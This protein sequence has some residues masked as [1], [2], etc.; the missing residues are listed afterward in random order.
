MLCHC[1]SSRELSQVPNLVFSISLFPPANTTTCINYV[2]AQ[3]Q[4]LLSA[5]L[6][7]HLSRLHQIQFQDQSQHE[8]NAASFGPA[9]WP[10]VRN[11]PDFIKNKP[12]FQWIHGF[13]NEM[14]TK[15]A[16]TLLGNVHIIPV[17]SP[18]ISREFL[19]TH[20]AVFASRLNTIVSEYSSRGFLSIA[21]VPK[22]EQWKK[23][24][25]IVASNVINQTTFKWLH[26][27][28][29]EEA[30]NLVRF[31]YNQIS[32]TSSVI[33][34]RNTVRQ[35]SVNVSRKMIFSTRYF[36]N[37]IGIGIEEEEHVESLFTVLGH[38][39][40]FSLSD[41]FPWMRVLD[42]DGHGKNCQASC[43]YHKQVP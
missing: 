34:V 26:E 21:V 43:G 12:V 15:I 1:R 28:R 8:G 22:G 4:L 11:L 30:D 35:Y 2:L 38:L 3:S 9:P 29:L 32:N 23:V 25:R 42:L 17:T 18:E 36:G 37:E 40:A 39:F 6:R 20:D 27:K 41:Y 7:V 16:C 24:R 14:K 33:N 10:L 31:I 19:K 5:F 13:M